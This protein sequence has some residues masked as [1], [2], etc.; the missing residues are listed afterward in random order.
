MGKQVKHLLAYFQPKHYD[1]RLNLNKTD[2]AF[3]GEVSVTG[4]KVGRPTKRITL[5][6]SGL[7]VH[8]ATIVKSDKSSTQTIPVTRIVNQNSFDEVRLHTDEQMYPGNYTIELEFSGKITQQMN[9]VYPCNFTH[10]G[11]KKQLLATQFES[12]HAREVFPCVDEPAA[13]A[14][15]GLT[16]GTDTG[17]IVLSNTPVQTQTTEGNNLITQ[18]EKTPIMST[19]L[20]AFVVGEMDYKET[21]TNAGVVIRGYTTPDNVAYVEF[22]LDVAKQCIEFYDEYFAISYPLE[23]C[24]L[25]ALPDFSSGAME[26]W[27][28]IT[29]RE[30]TLLVDPAH[31][32]LSTKQYV[33]MV[34]AH[35][36]AHQW[37]GNLVTM[38]WWTDLWLNEGFASWVE[39][40]AIDKLF[41]SWDMWTQFTSSEQQQAM[42]LD[43]LEHTHPV[44]VPVNSPDEIRTIFD[45]ISYSKGASVIHMLHEYLGPDDFRTGLQYYLKTHAYSNTDT[46]DLWQALEDSSHKPVR[47]FMHDWT[48]QSGYP[49]VRA[50]VDLPNVSLRQHRFMTNQTKGEI[51]KTLWPIPL[52]IPELSDA[53]TLKYKSAELTYTTDEVFKLN[54]G[55]SGFY[56]TVY[57]NS[58]LH[59]LGDYIKKGRLKPLDRIGIL[60]DAFE[61][62]RY[63]YID[64]TETIT[65][66]ESFFEED[67]YAVWEIITS[68]IGS[69]RLVMN[70]ETLREAIKPFVR[71]LIASQ[72]KRLGWEQK[73]SDSHFDRLL[74]PIIIGMAASADESWVVEK[75]QELFAS[76]EDVND[77]RADLGSVPSSKKIKRGFIHPDLRG[78]VFGT[79][80]KRGD[81]KTFDKLVRLHNK[82]HL[83]DEKITLAAAITSFRQPE[84][85]SE[86]LD[87][88]RSSQVRLQDVSYWII[89]SFMNRHAKQQTWQWLQS[90]WSWLE[91]NF[92]N[93]LSFYRMPIYVARAFSDESFRP[94]FET[95]FTEKMSGG[96]DRSYNQSLEMLDW[97]TA[98]K[99][100]SLK[101]TKHHFTSKYHQ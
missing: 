82:A 3:G 53:D 72:L 13:K 8:K 92:S 2:M 30:Q 75:C 58:H 44:E 99:K 19:Y 48:S 7:Q 61:A 15:F 27:G 100:R 78:A 38:R 90:N 54:R 35:E 97:Q 43:T 34:V 57:N 46:V 47:A 86:S 29:F 22:A 93:D 80:A 5:H 4:K 62:A 71:A 83:S 60:A 12:H 79:V 77:L 20:L 87:M 31:T 11:K 76:I 28:C 70:D 33:A 10:E 32:A 66:L 21:K 23:K 101:T 95:F 55:Q 65:L 85:V 50:T 63:G 91:D 84:L 64:T 39:F 24:D 88:I 59:V 6:Q 45:A 40:L 81:K 96:L 26:N 9:G 25:I 37:F 17:E 52:L 56:R 49:V 98:W 1:L 42:R 74:R 36:L 41:P 16:L 68:W 14:T 73:D 67:N 18:F 51:S 94:E 89:Y 69:L